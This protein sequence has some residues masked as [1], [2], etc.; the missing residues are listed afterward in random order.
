MFAEPLSEIKWAFQLHYYICFRTRSRRRLFATT[1]R[2][3][4]LRESLESACFEHGYHLIESN[5][6]P[7]HL[8]CIVSLQPHHSISTVIQRLKASLSRDLRPRLSLP[9]PLWE[10]GYLAR[11]L[12]RVR[13]DAV[14]RYLDSQAEHHGYSKRTHPPVFRYSANEP[15]VL[16]AE[17]GAFDL[18]HHLV[19]AT[20]YRRGVF[21]SALGEAL[22]SYW[23]RVAAKRGFAIDR[24][25]I[26]PDHVHMLVRVTPKLSVHGCALSLLNNAQHWVAGHHPAELISAKLDQLWQ[27]SGYSGTCGQTSTALMK[28]FLSRP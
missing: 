1:D 20:R 24:M 13:I 28:W 18:S 15:V 11:S 21:G 2:V 6:Y 8:R 26:L 16:K 19:F 12:G 3:I 22:A 27:P 14:K 23:V 4:L 5:G 17:H 10:R 7:D 9:S 25:T